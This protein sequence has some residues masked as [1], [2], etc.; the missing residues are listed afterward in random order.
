[1][2]E[3]VDSL[4]PPKPSDIE[5]KEQK[6]VSLI[7]QDQEYVDQEKLTKPEEMEG[8]EVSTINIVNE[9]YCHLSTN[10]YIELCLQI[11]N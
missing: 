9:Q 1:M 4:F 7:Q 2:S 8:K 10:G 11:A 6:Q 5:K 3:P